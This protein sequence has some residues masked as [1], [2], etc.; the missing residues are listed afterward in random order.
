MSSKDIC[1]RTTSVIQGYF[2]RILKKFY[3]KIVMRIIVSE[4]IYQ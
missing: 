3:C 2:V 4:Y 1:S